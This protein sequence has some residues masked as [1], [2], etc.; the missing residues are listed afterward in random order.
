M[1]QAN[2][3][4]CFPGAG[5]SACTHD[6]FDEEVYTPLKRK[7]SYIWPARGARQAQHSTGG[8]SFVSY[9][10]LSQWRS[11][12]HRRQHSG[13]CPQ[14]AGAWLLQAAQLVPWS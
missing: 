13:L 5:S 7:S 6:Q 3:V 10:T 2:P 1:H 4:V 9:T 12:W 8:L 11:Q 14:P